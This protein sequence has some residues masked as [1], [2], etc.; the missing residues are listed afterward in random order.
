VG[1]KEIRYWGGGLA[2]PAAIPSALGRLVED[3]WLFEGSGVNTLVT[4]T[5]EGKDKHLS[6]LNTLTQGKNMSLRSDGKSIRE[7]DQYGKRPTSGAV[8]I[9]EPGR[10]GQIGLL[11]RRSCREEGL[12]FF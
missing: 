5:R 2:A 9:C 4:T 11:T 8:P 6:A 7:G 3:G 1:E 10:Q 12:G